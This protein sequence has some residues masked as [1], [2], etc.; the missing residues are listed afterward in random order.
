MTP[1]QFTYW[2]QGFNEIREK[3]AVGLSEREWE[4]IRDRLQTVFHKVTP[5]RGTLYNPDPGL[6][7]PNG[8]GTTPYTKGHEITC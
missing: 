5:D 6:L 1:E 8:S 2:L 4:V 3:E 7:E